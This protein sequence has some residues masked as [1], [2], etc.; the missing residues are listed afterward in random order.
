[1][2]DAG[3]PYLV[4]VVPRA[5]R[6]SPLDPD[7][8]EWRD[9]RRGRARAA[10]RAARATAS[11]SAS[12]ASTTARAHAQPAPALRAARARA[13]R[14][15]RA[16]RRRR[17][18][19]CATPR[20][21]ARVFVAALQPLRRRA[22][23]R[24]SPSASTSSAAARRASR[25][26]ACTATP[27][28]RGDAVYLPA[29]APLYGTAAGAAARRSSV[30][31]ARGAHCGCRSCCTGA[32][33]PT[34][35]G[36]DLRALRR[37][38]RAVRHA[39]GRTSW[40]PCNAAAKPSE[41]RL[42]HDHRRPAAAP[43]SPPSRCSTRSSTRGHETRPAHRP[44]RHRPRHAACASSR[45]HRAQALAAQL[46]ADRRP[47][48]PLLVRRL[49]RALRGRGALRRAARPLQEGA[50]AGPLAARAAC[51]RR[52]CGRSGA[53]CRSRCAGA[54]RGGCTVGAAERADRVLAVSEGTRDSLVEV[55]VPEPEVIV[56][57]NVLRTDEIDFTAAGPRAPSASASASPRRPSSSAASP[58]STRRSATTSWSTPSSAS[59]T[60]ARAPGARRRRAR[61]RPSCAALGRAARRPRRTSSPRRA[62]TSPT[63]CRPSTS[64][65]FCPSPTEGAAARRDPRDARPSA[66][67]CRP[68]PRASPT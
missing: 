63:C 8:T 46:P 15:A 64:R 60:T 56:V 37:S 5:R 4:A 45:R 32:G 9:A 44:A 39:A 42:R 24:S 43:S 49:R 58:A 40:M 6:A 55:G 12:T 61:P 65:V 20:S 16:P 53:R 23:T 50:A 10:A 21:D 51:A 14:A 30:S 31:A 35:G 41:D 11:R 2:R 68:A 66:R 25:C 18:R 22:S 54:C 62:T 34:K 7:G 27:L 33:R 13:R 1:M 36:K 3:V 28:W 17:R 52:S 67:A 26:W 59:A 48:W 47:R 19:S 38:R 29:Y 57:P